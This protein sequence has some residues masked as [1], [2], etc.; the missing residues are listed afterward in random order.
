M[1]NETPVELQICH[2][3]EENPLPEHPREL[4]WV[5][6]QVLEC[7]SNYRSHLLEVLQILKEKFRDNLKPPVEFVIVELT[8]SF[9]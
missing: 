4:G 3:A 8:A 2:L 7:V 1:R 9:L 5:L 6:V